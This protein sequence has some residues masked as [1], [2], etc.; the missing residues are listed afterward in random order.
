[1]ERARAAADAFLAKWQEKIDAVMV[2]PKPNDAG[3]A[4]LLWE[5]RTK[6]ARLKNDER[7]SWIEQ[8]GNDPIIPS[9]LLHGPAGLTNLSEAERGIC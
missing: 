1:L 3:T 7:L 2:M 4:T 8:F 9:A 6:F 5:I